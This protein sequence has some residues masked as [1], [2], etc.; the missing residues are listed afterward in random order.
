M[1]KYFMLVDF[2]ILWQ[3]NWNINALDFFLPKNKI[4][5]HANNKNSTSGDFDDGGSYGGKL[6]CK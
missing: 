2:M 4:Y 5:S 6:C 1:K 3:M